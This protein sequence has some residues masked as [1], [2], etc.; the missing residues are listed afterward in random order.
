MD[1]LD[2]G[3]VPSRH[4]VNSVKTPKDNQST[5]PRQGNSPINLILSSS[6]NWL[7]SWAM[8]SVLRAR[9]LTPRRYLELNF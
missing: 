3:P 7:L 9:S 6:C 5:E 4:Q 8:L 2:S 1:L